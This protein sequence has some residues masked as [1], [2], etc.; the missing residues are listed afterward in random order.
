MGNFE[1]TFYRWK[2]L[3]GENAGLREW[4]QSFPR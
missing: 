4:P 1:T 3:Y 2:Q